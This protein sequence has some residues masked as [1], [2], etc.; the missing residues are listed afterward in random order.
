[1]RCSE[2]TTPT[3]ATSRPVDDSAR[4]HISRTK[5]PKSCSKEDAPGLVQGDL[6]DA[7]TDAVGAY[8]SVSNSEEQA[9]LAMMD[10][11]AAYQLSSVGLRGADLMSMMWS[12]ETRSI[13]L[14]RPI[15]EFALD[16][17]MAAKIDRKAADPN[18]R[19][20]VLLKKLFLRY[21]SAELLVQKQGFTGFSTESTAYLGQTEDFRAF[22]TLRVHPTSE[23]IASYSRATM[24]KL[25]DVEY[26]LRSRSA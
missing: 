21:F 13:L 14:R 15:V 2:A 5:N 4:R 18:L 11:D 20:K 24:W 6:A 10:G 25:A 12:V 17:P 22:D 19:T 9:A 7:W 23:A 16:L 3:C 1:M 26:F 8:R